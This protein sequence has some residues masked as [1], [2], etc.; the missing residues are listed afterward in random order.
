MPMR[1][2]ADDSAWRIEMMNPELL[3]EY[4]IQR[5]SEQTFRLLF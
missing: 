1:A 3:V 5:I 2:S 4:L